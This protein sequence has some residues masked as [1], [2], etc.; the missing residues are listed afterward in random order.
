[1]YHI[2]EDKRAIRSADLLSE[3]LLDCLADKDFD[4]VSVSEL[5]KRSFVSRSTFY[6]LFDTTVDVLHYLCDKMFESVVGKLSRMHF[7]DPEEM[8]IAFNRE[9]M[10]RGAIIDAVVNSHRMD[11]L[12]NTHVKYADA[13]LP[14]FTPYREG[15]TDKEKECVLSIL[16]ASLCSYIGLWAENGKRE[17]PEELTGIVMKSFMLIAQVTSPPKQFPGHEK[18]S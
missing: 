11:I 5:N 16:T 18:K 15:L 2:P 7:S 8:M 10:S 14:C 9:I 4:Q 1:M 3:A 6:R 13:F 12:Y 17:S